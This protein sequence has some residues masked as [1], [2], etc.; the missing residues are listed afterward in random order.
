MQ[1][2][3]DLFSR[4]GG[5][6][7]QIERTAEELR[8]LGV[9]VAIDCSARPDLADYGLVHL[10][11]IDWPA[12]VYLQAQNAQAQGKPVVLSPIHHSFAEIERYEREARFGLRRVVNALFTVREQRERFK[13]FC[14]MLAD[15]QKISSTLVEFKRGIKSEQRELLELADLVLVQTAAE[16][17]DAE[18]DLSLKVEKFRRVVN[19]SDVRFASAQAATFVDEFGLKDFALCVGRV[20]PRKNQLAV[21]EAAATLRSQI[22]SL[23]LL[24]VGQISRRHPEYAWRFK[25]L[26]RKHDWVY[27]VPSIP[28]EEMGSCYA[29]AKVHVLASWFETTGLVNLEAALAGANV[30]AAGGRAREYQAD[31]AEYCDPGDSASISGAILA[32]WEKPV[33]PE[34]RKHILENFTWE[35][36][37]EQTLTAYR[38]IVGNG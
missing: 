10:F 4:R 25:R 19:G 7:V 28:Y 32:A 22:P 13:D 33:D 2:R 31:F 23:T 20:E 21:A 14:R 5:D 3:V 18:E 17:K 9:G 30:V 24:F 6:T 35:K 37:A 15:P 27:H 8:K 36:A 12:Q 34:F 16:A 1:S 26:V 38:E 11:N 29:A